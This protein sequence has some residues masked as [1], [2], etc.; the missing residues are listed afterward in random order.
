MKSPNVRERERE[1]F[2]SILMAEGIYLDS[3]RRRR[4]NVGTTENSFRKLK[5][6]EKI[7]KKTNR[8]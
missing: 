7:P 3:E 6:K 4:D 2:G 5:R 1:S 8:I